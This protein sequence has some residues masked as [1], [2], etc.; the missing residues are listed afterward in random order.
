[1]T[2]ETI[3]QRI[4]RTRKALNLTQK[5]LAKTLTEATHGS[6][7]QWESDTTTPSAK[8]L[9]D[10]SIALECDFVWLLNGGK[11]SNIAP[12]SLKS[13]KVPLINCS[14]VVLLNQPEKLDDL[15]NIEYLMTSLN[16]SKGSF[17]IRIDEDSMEPEFKQGDI[18][19]I[20]P[21][22][23][24]TPG[25]FVVAVKNKNEAAIFKKYRELGDNQFELTPLN[26]DYRT[27]STVDK[28]IKIV[29]TMVEHRIF[30]RKR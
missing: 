1:M 22:I 5:D 26:P 3:G 24:P 13:F 23:K 14:Q 6:I 17:A 16:V 11:K 28:Q 15:P 19:I 20:D 29:G 25:E 21:E 12:A 7:S 10:L 9:Y 2:T 4:R 8:N 18:V 27:D 30:R